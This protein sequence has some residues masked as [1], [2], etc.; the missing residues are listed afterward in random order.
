MSSIPHVATTLQTVLG[1]DLEPIGRRTGLIQRLRKFSA[2]ILLKMLVFTLLKCP[3][4]KTKNYVSSAAQLGLI[5]TERALKKRFT[6]QLVTFLRAVLERLMQHLVASTP[7]DTPLLAKFTSVRVGDSTTVMLPADCAREFP[8]CGGKSGSG[9]AALKIQV[10]WDLT[11]GRLLK[12]LLEPGRHS[13]AKSAAV[14]ETPPAGSLSL[15]DLGYFCLKRFRRWTAAGAFWISRW[16][17][18]TVVLTP[19]GTPLDLLQRLRQHPWDG[20]LDIAVLLGSTARVACRLIALR[21]PPEV[22]A[23]RRQKAYEK[24]QKSGRTPTRA[25]LQWC[26]WTIL[27]TN[28]SLELLTWKEVVVLYR[29]RWQIELLFKLWKSHNRLAT[30][31]ESQSV[32]WQMAEFW[33]K[34]IGVIL[35]HWL[36]LTMTWLDCRR[37]LMKAATVLRDWITVLQE[38]LGDVARLCDALSR[39]QAA[40][41]AAARV[42]VR[43][44]K[45][46]WFQL[47]KN[48]ELL[49]YTY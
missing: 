6:P 43:K 33:A 3:S 42:N 7:V 37:S 35:Q 16:Q 49:D 13:D 2:E 20:P 44:K 28:C 18:G 17:P 12:V 4:P 9:T 48:P 15:W 22:A 26:D 32:A 47:L 25:H 10:L 8:G 14:E 46:S 36:L 11:T 45:P 40:I 21:V 24:A 30:H 1:P 29:T 31:A 19:E 38:A 5:I 27:V 34:L 23:R 41:A 39:M